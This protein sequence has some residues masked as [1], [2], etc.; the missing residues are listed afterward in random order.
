MVSKFLKG[1]ALVLAL[2]GTSLS[3]SGADLKI[4]TY[5]EIPPAKV[6]ST[7]WYSTD[8]ADY[9]R[10]QRGPIILRAEPNCPER[11]PRYKLQREQKEPTILRAE[12]NC[13]ERN[14]RYK[15]QREQKEP[16]VIRPEPAMQ[17][18]YPG[19]NPRYD[20]KLD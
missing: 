20:F 17:K 3:S 1:L 19:I 18:N 5:Q 9:F 11:N 8:P 10:E 15:L 4:E 13:P 14:P 16:I 6:L 2:S 7:R 12:P